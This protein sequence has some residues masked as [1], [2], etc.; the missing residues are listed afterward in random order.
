MKQ[1]QP[2]CGA[3]DGDATNV[4]LRA[5]NSTKPIEKHQLPLSSKA[6]FIQGSRTASQDEICMVTE[7]STFVIRAQVS[8]G[9]KKSHL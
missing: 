7:V 3:E 1:R 5:K 9:L 6:L 8:S 2:T 4:Y